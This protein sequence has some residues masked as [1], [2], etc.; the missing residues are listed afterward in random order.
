EI[1][2]IFKSTD[3]FM[4][5]SSFIF[6][7]EVIDPA[8]LK[9]QRAGVLIT[10]EPDA[11][12]AVSN[13]AKYSETLM[14]R[15]Q[16]RY[17]VQER[18]TEKPDLSSLLKPGETLS[19][20]SAKAVLEKYGIPVTRNAIAASADD[21]VIKAK[22]IGY[23]VALKVDSP[24]IPHKT[25]AGGLRLNLINDDQ[26]RAA[27]D[28]IIRNVRGYK[29][30]ARIS[31]ISV[32]EMLP[33]GTEVIIG[34]TRD[35]AFGPVIMFGLGGIFVEVLKDVSFRVAPVSPGDAADMIEEI[36]GYAVLKGVRGKP[37]ADIKAIA[38]I[39]LRVSALVTDYGDSIEELDINPL[40]VYP[41]GAK[42]A[43]ALLVVREEVL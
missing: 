3:K 39:I 38:D 24:D 27:Y 1:I 31:G 20:S 43:D 33:E 32:Q 6:P 8:T 22:I 18:S 19:E 41:G 16:D 7:G 21:A 23:P 5:I 11:I 28:D 13:L 25:E 10:F 14:K 4:L 12:K 30:N 26:V 34:V 42:A 40:V 37:P 15:K 29:P 36:K 2:D 35:P 9:L 17:R